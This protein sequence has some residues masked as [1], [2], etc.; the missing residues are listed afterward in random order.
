M[1][2]LSIII[3]I[4]AYCAFS[5][6]WFAA[7][8]QGISEESADVAK[9]GGRMIELHPKGR[10]DVVCFAIKGYGASNGGVALSC[11]KVT[12]VEVELRKQY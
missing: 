1:I 3:S 8:T 9:L 10:H 7:K 5:S 2:L 4:T 12:P 11:V 6:S